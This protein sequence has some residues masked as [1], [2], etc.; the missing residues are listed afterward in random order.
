ML[1]KV[2]I[3]RFIIQCLNITIYK[4]INYLFYYQLCFNYFLLIRKQKF[5]LEA[6]F[7]IL[8]K[9]QII[10]IKYLYIKNLRNIILC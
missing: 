7:I 4:V 6:N 2:N 1:L 10:F 9:K 5:Y 3:I 8:F